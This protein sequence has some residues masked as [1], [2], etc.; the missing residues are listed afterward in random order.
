MKKVINFLKNNKKGM[1]ILGSVFVLVLVIFVLRNTFGDPNTGYLKNQTVDGLSFEKV[2]LE[3]KDGVTTFTALVYNESG[4]DYSLSN[5]NVILKSSSKETTLTGYIGE[6]IPK[7]E[8]RVL[9]ISID[10]DLSDSSSLTYKIN[11]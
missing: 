3:Y 9:R 8:A 10:D 7:D 4:N 1:I 6:N 2:N 5:I 11:K